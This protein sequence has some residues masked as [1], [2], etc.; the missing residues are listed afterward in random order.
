[1]TVEELQKKLDQ[2]RRTKKSRK[3][4]IPQ[5]FWEEAIKLTSEIPPATL[6]AK[7]NLN[8]A[9]LKRRL[10]ILPKL[11]EKVLFK[12]LPRQKIEKAPIFELTTSS[13]LTLKVY[14]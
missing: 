1:M 12:E 6:A 14:Q 5:E 10:G 2:W 9:D 8:S 3:D 7:L 11:K 13:G 4:R